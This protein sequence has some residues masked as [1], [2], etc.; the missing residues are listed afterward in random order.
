MEEDDPY[1]P[2]SLFLS[3][4]VYSRPGY[5]FM[6]TLLLLCAL[7]LNTLVFSQ[8]ARRYTFPEVG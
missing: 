8:T 1:N 2:A 6:R 5:Q 7:V 4:D 3:R